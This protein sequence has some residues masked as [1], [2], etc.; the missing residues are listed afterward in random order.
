MDYVQQFESVTGL[1]LNTVITS[2]LLV[3]VGLAIGQLLPRK[4]ISTDMD[5]F[6]EELEQRLG[7]P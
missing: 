2:V 4:D 1:S 7:S 5:A 6:R 3:L